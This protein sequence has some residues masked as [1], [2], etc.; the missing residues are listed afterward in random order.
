M[1]LKRRG[2]VLA[3]VA[4]VG[5]ALTIVAAAWAYRDPG[6]YFVRV[7][8]YVIPPPDLPGENPYV[9]PASSAV[10]M[11]GVLATEVDGSTRYTFNSPEA[12]L[13]GA[14]IT[15]GWWARIPDSGGQWSHVYNDPILDIQAVDP[16]PGVAEAIVSEKVGTALAALD[17]IQSDAGVVA[18][19]RFTTR[20]SPGLPLQV[21]Y[22]RGRTKMAGIATLLI[23]VCL[24]MAV[25]IRLDA[26]LK[27]RRA[28]RDRRV[29]PRAAMPQKLPE[30][31]G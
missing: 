3:L 15:Q 13:V 26:V 28:R 4:F 31:V 12:T 20:L 22:L 27:R 19:N 30:Q 25:V 24:T 5:L 8:L 7:Q 16:R 2:L 1:P 6:V 14:G 9:N 18:S 29:R 23:G 11:A 21:Q 10:A 17:K